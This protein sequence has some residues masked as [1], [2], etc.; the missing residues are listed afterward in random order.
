M[1]AGLLTL[2]HCQL[3]RV[4]LSKQKE[5][6]AHS[7]NY[8]AN[9]ILWNASYQLK[10]MYYLRK[11][12]RND[13]GI[14]Q[15]NSKSY[16]RIYKWLTIVNVKLS[17]SQLNKLRFSVENQ[18]GVRLRTNIKMFDGDKLPHELL[19]TTRQKTNLRNLF[20][21]NMST[22]VKLPKTQISKII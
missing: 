21:N 2:P 19:L 6:D 14:L 1:F 12:K 15:R 5:L 11:A 10:C 13:I 8:S 18:T 22:D 20:E 4:N 3:I 16:V 17:D 9:E 7:K